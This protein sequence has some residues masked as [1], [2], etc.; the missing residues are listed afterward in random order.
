MLV[1][2]GS[3]RSGGPLAILLTLLPPRPLHDDRERVGVGEGHRP[4]LQRSPRPYADG[5][6]AVASPASREARR[7]PAYM[8]TVH[9]QGG[10][11]RF[12]TGNGSILHAV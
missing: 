4:V 6:A 5:A 8:Q 7:V 11:T 1:V 10:P 12:Y 9:V 2:V 3:P